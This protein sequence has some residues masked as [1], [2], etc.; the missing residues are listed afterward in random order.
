MATNAQKTDFRWDIF[1]QEQLER[2]LMDET[3]G[4]LKTISTLAGNVRKEKAPITQAERQLSDG[5]ARKQFESLGPIVGQ[6]SLTA[7]EKSKPLEPSQ[8]KKLDNSDPNPYVVSINNGQPK[9]TFSISKNQH[10]R[11][12]FIRTVC[13]QEK[14]KVYINASHPFYSDRICLLY[15]SPSPRDLSTS[16]MPSSA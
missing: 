3:N 5:K 6:T 10:P 12:P 2:Q 9:L 15:T 1:T 4:H 11:E 13:E 7:G 8:I 16:R 14:V